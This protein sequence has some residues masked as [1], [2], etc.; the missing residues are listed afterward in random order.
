MKRILWAFLFAALAGAAAAQEAPLT[1]VNFLRVND[2]VCTAGQPSLEDLVRLKAQGVRAVINLRRPSEHA[3]EEEAAQARQLGLR[4]FNIPVDGNN[5]RDA[6]VA[7]FL[8]ISSDTANRPMFIH[9]AS[10]NR[11]G[12]FWMIRRVLVDQWTLGAAEEE[13][14]KIGLRTAAVRDFAL[15]YIARQRAAEDLQAIRNYARV[16]D[17]VHIGAQP[18]PEHFEKLKAA[19]VKAVLNLRTPEEHR[20][21]EEEAQ[22][23]AAG[24]KY[25]NIA[26][27]YTGPKDS[28][29][30]EFLRLLDDPANR[31]VY[32]HCTTT[33]RVAALWMIRRVL[34]DGISLEQAESEASKLGLATAPDLR[35]FARSYIAR[36]R[37]Q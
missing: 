14:R 30:D 3:A 34:R 5:I 6:Q 19:G 15:D 25:L 8:R 2:D 35:D 23:Q 9:C 10:A 36:N 16:A 37:K 7:E 11:V 26:M 22:A 18:R 31:P 28:D 17:D 13:A 12:G 21:A 33:I 27:K 20:A 32:I 4:Y 29:A 24:I 1:A